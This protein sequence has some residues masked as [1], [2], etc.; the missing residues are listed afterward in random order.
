MSNLS[1]N[2]PQVL[3]LLTVQSF[4]IFSCK[5]Y[6]QSDFDIDHPAIC[7]CKFISCVV[8]RECLPEYFT[9]KTLLAFALFI[10]YSEAKLACCSRCLLTSYFFILRPYHDFFFLM[11]YLGLVDHRIFQ[12]QLLQN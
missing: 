5:E 12:P 11:L 6:N 4:S 3:C 2:E 9:G 7:M 10:L 8:G 1:H